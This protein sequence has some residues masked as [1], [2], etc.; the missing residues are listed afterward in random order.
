M[1]FA[2]AYECMQHGLSQVQFSCELSLGSENGDSKIHT[3]CVYVAGCVHGRIYSQAHRSLRG[4]QFQLGSR[5]YGC[6]KDCRILL[7]G[8]NHHASKSADAQSSHQ[9]QSCISPQTRRTRRGCSLI[10]WKS[11]ICHTAEQLARRPKKTPLAETKSDAHDGSQY[12][13]LASQK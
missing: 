3:V 8:A 13:A 1:L 2:G 11:S 7:R 6:E 4:L 5:D 9:E 12:D 10:R